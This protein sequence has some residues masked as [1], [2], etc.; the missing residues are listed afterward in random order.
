MNRFRRNVAAVLQRADGKI[1]VGERVDIPGAWQFP[2]GGAQQGEDELCALRRELEEEIGLIPERY[3]VI[4]TRAGY[5]YQFPKGQEKRGWMGQDQT[6]FLC[7]YLGEGREDEFRLEGEHPE[8]A[9]VMWIEPEA[10]RLAWLPE[11]KWEV[12]RQVFR[13]LF[14]L[15][16]E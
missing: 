5:R 16:L 6:Y 11:F 15:R 10:F 13:D 9:R 3:E 7:R 1:L 4:A 8:F 12:Y 14:D 2:Q